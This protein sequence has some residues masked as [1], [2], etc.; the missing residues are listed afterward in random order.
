MNGKTLTGAVLAA[1]VGAMFL[2]NP[3]FAENGSSSG[4][5]AS[6][7]KC[8][9]GNSC[10]GQSSCASATNSCMGQN[11]CKGKGWVTTASVKECT[12]KGG[13]PAPPEKKS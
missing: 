3:T 6:Q 11:S 4:S 7:V 12:D 10:K 5:S 2:A 8:I 9:G 1:A 13:H